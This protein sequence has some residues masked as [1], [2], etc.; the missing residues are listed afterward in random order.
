[1][2]GVKSRALIAITCLVRHAALKEVASTPY[3]KESFRYKAMIT[4]VDKAL[5][6]DVLIQ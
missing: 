4:H 1:V 5:I 2:E 3:V 6:A